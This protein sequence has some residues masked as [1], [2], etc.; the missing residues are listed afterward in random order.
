MT[1][2][3]GADL[4]S[5]RRHRADEGRQWRGGVG[6][7]LA[8]ALAMAMV[9]ALG[10]ARLEAGAPMAP[11]A[12]PPEPAMAD[13]LAALLA[14]Q[15][16]APGRSARQGVPSDSAPGGMSSGSCGTFWCLADA[17]PPR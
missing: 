8:L 16:A 1:N 2:I 12:V 14:A 7:A 9:L 5:V 10:A 13:K 4:P 3:G 17:R 11:L 6:P 15:W